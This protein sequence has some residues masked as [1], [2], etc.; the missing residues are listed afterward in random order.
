MTKALP[1]EGIRILDLTQYTAGP[2]CTRVLGDYGADIIKI[3]P[4]RGDPARQLPPFA[5]DQPGPE[6][7]GLFL[8]LNTNKR[9]VVLDLESEADRDTL[10][11]LAA[12][13]DA[14]VESFRPGTLE[15]L[16][17]GYKTLAAA[18]P[19][20]VVTSISNFGQDGPYR[21]WQGTD[22]TLYAMGGPLLWTGEPDQ[23]PIRTAGRL[24][25]YHAGY[26]AAL[27]TTIGLRGAD[28]RGEGEHIDVS[29][30]E[31]LTHNID[32]R[33]VN[34]FIYQYSGRRA[35][36][37][38]FGR[39]LGNAMLPCADGWFMLGAGPWSGSASLPTL[40]KL[41]GCGHLLERP[42][43]RAATVYSDPERITEFEACVL[44]WM[45]QR[46]KAEIT[47]AC[48]QHGL[49]GA[50]LNTVADLL[51]DPSFTA[52][53]FFQEIDHPSTGPVRYPGYHFRL[54]DGAGD[55]PPRRRAPLLGEH[56]EQVLSEVSGGH[57]QSIRVPNFMPTTVGS[58][59]KPQLPLEGVRVLDLT[60][61]Y[62]GSFA[63]MQ[64]ADWGAEII[65]VESCQYF[66][67][68]T[69]G[70]LARPRADMI[71]KG[72][73]PPWYPDDDPG[74]RPWNRCAQFNA[75]ARGKL[76]MT[77]DLMRPEGQEIFEALVEKADGIIEN[78]LPRY[79]ERLGVTWDRLSSINPRLILVRAPAFGLTGPY[80]NLRTYGSHMEA[81]VGH[82]VLRA[83][84]GLAFDRAP[85]GV[86]A[87][88]LSGLGAALAL[89]LGLR[90]RERTGRGLQ[91]EL[92]TAENLVPFLGEFI[93][94]YTLNGRLYERMANDHW[95]LAPHN[96]YPCRGG[97][98]WV[99]IAVRDEDDW[100]RLHRVV[101]EPELADP[102]F[103]SMESRHAHRSELD[104]I[105]AR[106]TAQRDAHWVMRR[107]QS[108]GVPAGVAMNEPDLLY[109]P[110][111][112]ARGFFQ[113]IES[114]ET[115]TQRYVGRAWRA[116]KTPEPAWRPPPR[117]GE[118]NEYVYREL[119]GVS[120]EE[121]SRL[122]ELGHIGV[123]FAASIP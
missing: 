9:S 87:D 46:T 111:H 18:N 62:A 57:D 11:A 112:D 121:Y 70:A 96:V 120:V 113:E 115:G 5:G 119:L 72:I 104:A 100:R 35:S 37:G 63:T 48:Q 47:E 36:R 3:E 12:R 109:D 93:M 53:E 107:L 66:P 90:H 22:L 98:R 6:R 91:I 118:H 83:Y 114:P 67:I 16:G 8:F 86:P 105:I 27:A 24:G 123:D 92:A 75:H 65:R 58:T 30:F 52:R 99:A 122:E 69:R 94:D 61:A 40:M 38:S 74:L 106:W 80:R 101:R 21:D 102:R 89:T 1:L 59:S 110:Q 78:N 97:D 14:L 31:S 26:L 95:Y 54:H 44:P 49:M 116:S 41:V 71:P 85:S 39:G 88:A 10:L 42:E 50:P 17:I 33:L 45:L 19:R 4:P 55:M 64:L 103:S 82:P 28:L 117:L 56:T 25:T 7:S 76:S 2:F 68:Q 13:A 81:V 15:R 29:I 84:P 51:E 32:R 77:V 60:V 34:L 73:T 20:I 43:W 79:M 23:Q 108:E